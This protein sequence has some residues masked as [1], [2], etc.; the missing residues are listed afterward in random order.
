MTKYASRPATVGRGSPAGTEQERALLSRC[1][2]GEQAA[3]GQLYAMCHRPLLRAIGG[4]PLLGH[5]NL[6]LIDEIAARVW[7]ELVRDDAERLRR[8]EPGKG[9]L[10]A[11]ICGFARNVALVYLRSERRRQARECLVMRPSS[12]SVDE[13]GLPATVQLEEFLTTLT[14]A[15][16]AYYRQVIE[17][18]SPR[19]VGDQAPLEQF[20]DANSRQLRHRLRAKLERYLG[21]EDSPGDGNTQRSP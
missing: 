19:I 2:A 8:F 21:Q 4:L 16:L 14:R 5:K 9:N 17:R 18:K 20:S 3:W 12:P 11:F 7:Y 1:L 13:S 15:E 6:E 10:A